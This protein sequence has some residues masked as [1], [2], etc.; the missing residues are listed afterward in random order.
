MYV[1]R[2]ENIAKCLV[3]VAHPDDEVIW[4]GGVIIRHP[5]WE[6]HIMSLCRVDDPDRAPRFR[7]AASLLGACAYMSDL[8]DSRVLMELSPDLG[9]IKQ[10]I[11]A[12]LPS[13]FD[14]IFT[15]GERGEYT[16]H[17]RHEQAHRAVREMVDSGSPAG[18]L[19]FFAYEG[20]AKGCGPG[21]ADDAQI[22]VRL[23]DEEFARKLS[24]VSD[25]YGFGE[26]AFEYEAAGRVEAFRAARPAN[27]QCLRVLL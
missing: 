9:E 21:P 10:R 6:W 24:I 7:R 22:R 2:L 14:L 23:S 26:G 15:H 19:L 8:D 3:V 12:M 25:I 5:A 13:Q 27:L 16:G 11:H 17:A 4:M 18:E 1:S 20:S